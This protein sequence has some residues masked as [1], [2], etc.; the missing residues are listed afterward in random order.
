LKLVRTELLIDRG[1]FSFSN[2]WRNIRKEIETAI[3]SMEHPPGAGKFI[4]ND[5]KGKGRKKGN[6][7]LP[8]KE[9]FIRHLKQQSKDWRTEVKLNIPARIEPGPIDVGKTVNDKLFAVEWETGNISSSHRALNKMSMGLLK[10][11]LVGGI[12]VLPTR[13]MY[14]YLTERIGNFE[15][16]EPY[17]EMWRALNINKGLL[18]VMGVEQDGLSKSVPKFSKMTAG[19]ALE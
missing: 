9:M 7:V 8:I 13:V 3:A 15:E 14:P 11:V 5:E 10:D 12:L 1:D 19:R 18:G 16:L 6:G 4:L 2:D 17:F